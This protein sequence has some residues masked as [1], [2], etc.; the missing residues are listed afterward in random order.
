[1]KFNEL[2]NVNWNDKIQKLND[3]IDFVKNKEKRHKQAMVDMNSTHEKKKP[4]KVVK[5]ILPEEY[6]D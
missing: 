1:L 3:D 6:Q 5:F 4:E 2:M